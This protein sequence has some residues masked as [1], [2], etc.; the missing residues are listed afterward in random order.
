MKILK[1]IFTIFIFLIIS[2]F[3]YSKPLENSDKLITGKLDNGLEYYIYKNKKPESNATLNL[4]VKVGS[5]MEENDEQGIAHFMEHMAFN[6]T[7]KFKKNEMI[8][9]LQSICLLYTSPS[10]RDRG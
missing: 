2:I 10:P 6:G 4:V 5:L 1:Q 3:S 7:T 9:Y 8:K